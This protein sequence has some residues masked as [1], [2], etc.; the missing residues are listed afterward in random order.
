MGAS[1]SVLSF[2]GIK[3]GVDKGKG[4][5]KGLCGEYSLVDG[6]TRLYVAL[7][8]VFSL[9]M[10]CELIVRERDSSNYGMK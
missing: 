5:R 3:F 6:D 9:G 10:I 7:S 2:M 1:L 8:G 4:D